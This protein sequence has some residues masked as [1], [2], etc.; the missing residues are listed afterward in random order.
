MVQ[1]FVEVPGGVLGKRF[2]EEP[3]QNLSHSKPN[4]L[5]TFSPLM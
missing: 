4:S 3:K 2:Y 1:Q 5:V